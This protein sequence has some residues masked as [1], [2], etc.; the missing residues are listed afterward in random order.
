[1]TELD[2]L[3]SADACA[4]LD[5]LFPQ[6]TIHTP[7]PQTRKLRLYLTA[8]CRIAW[9]E[10]PAACRA[11]TEFAERITDDPGLGHGP[12]QAVRQV[13]ERMTQSFGDGEAVAGCERD[14]RA[15]GVEVPPAGPWRGSAEDW[16]RV[17][18]L[19]LLPHLPEVPNYRS[20]AAADHRADL[21]RDLFANPF[22]P[23]RLAPGWVS[24]TVLGL[25]RGMYGSRDFA[26]MPVLA[27]ALEEAGCDAA[28]VLAH[29]RDGGPHARG[30]WVVDLVLGK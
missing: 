1:M 28:D 29:C 11:T 12:R 8:L 14:L 16:L 18:W 27:D 26:A 10:L 9:A 15:A 4:L 6:H 21:V 7:P 17:T 25:A 3:R 5:H 30:C 23:P 24:S 20:V 22:R 2:W 19:A 13:A